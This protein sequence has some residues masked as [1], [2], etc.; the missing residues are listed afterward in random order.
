MPI[1]VPQSV[2]TSYLVFLK[3]IKIDSV[4]PSERYC[5]RE[6]APDQLA[7][8]IPKSWRNY[9]KCGPNDGLRPAHY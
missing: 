8:C 6:T 4:L 5:K 3:L 2:L 9:L 1:D 7:F